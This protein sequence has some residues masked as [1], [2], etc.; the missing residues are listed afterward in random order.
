MSM[1]CAILTIA[2][3]IY[4]K[5]LRNTLGK[6]VISCLFSLAIVHFLEILEWFG[7]LEIYSFLGK[8]MFIFGIAYMIWHPV[9]GYHLWRT[10]NP[11]KRDEHRH[12]FLVY[13]SFVWIMTAGYAGL[14]FLKEHVV[15][16]YVIACFLLLWLQIQ[17]IFNI[18]MFILTVINIWKVKREI[19]RFE[20][21]KETT[22]TCFNF[23]TE[24]YVV[25]FRISLLMGVTWIVFTIFSTLDLFGYTSDALEK[26]LNFV[27]YCLGLLY[28]VLLILK[29]STLKLFMDSI[30][31]RRNEK[32]VRAQMKKDLAQ[33][34][35]HFQRKN[36]VDL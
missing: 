22:T 17:G 8:G 3:Y 7:L 32:L 24:T 33:I 20:R 12:Q 14:F 9:I 26:F 15:W 16:R 5:K 36:K 2:V 19:K 11:L 25:F 30:R 35:I 18:I 29:R 31:E 4:V 34:S 23:D 28:F 1:I 21:Q 13:S 6:C 10:L 27:P